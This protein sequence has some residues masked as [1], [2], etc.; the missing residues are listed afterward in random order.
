MYKFSVKHSPCFCRLRFTAGCPK[1]R[2]G[3]GRGGARLFVTAAGGSPVPPLPQ[4]PAL[5]PR[6]SLTTT[7]LKPRGT[8][9]GFIVIWVALLL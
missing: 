9:W 3:S 7:T 8:S 5:W 6:P 4:P 2:S 1:G